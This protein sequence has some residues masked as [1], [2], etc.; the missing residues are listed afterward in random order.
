[1][2]WRWRPSSVTRGCTPRSRPGPR[3]ACRRS[4]SPASMLSAG[5]GCT[6]RSTPSP[7]RRSRGS[8]S[9]T[10]A[11]R[12]SRS[13][14]GSSPR[15]PRSRCPAWWRRAWARA[16]VHRRHAPLRLRAH[17]LLL[18]RPHAGDRWLRRVPRHVDAGDPGRRR[19]RADQPRLRAHAAREGR[20]WSC[21]ARP[22]TTTAAGPS[23]GRS[24]AGAARRGHPRTRYATSSRACV[25]AP[26][27]RRGATA[28]TATTTSSSPA[29]RYA[30]AS[31]T[32]RSSLRCSRPSATR[33]RRSP[34]ARTAR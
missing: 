7:T 16:R 27:R 18:R 1:M 23:T 6:S 17:R 4:R 13:T 2:R 21:C 33:S 11:A 15:A 3:S 32:R 20:A 10:C 12:A 8:P 25:T 24:R 34:R 22:R 29:A 26:T 14:S 30:C 31:R 19:L 28:A 5:Q 9:P